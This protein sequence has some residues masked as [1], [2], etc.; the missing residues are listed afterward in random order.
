MRHDEC[1]ACM[2]NVMAGMTCYACGLKGPKGEGWAFVAQ[3]LKA[4]VA[5]LEALA[6]GFAPALEHA[7]ARAEKAEAEV[8]ALRG[9]VATVRGWAEGAED[10]APVYGNAGE[11]VGALLREALADGGIEWNSEDAQKTSRTNPRWAPREIADRL[12]QRGLMLIYEDRAE[13]VDI[14][15]ALTEI[16]G[17]EG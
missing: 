1:Q 17:K 11:H 4:R 3:D 13:V 16:M 8:A 9:V 2:G 12:M 7:Q 6:A 10:N 5:E 14:E 15:T